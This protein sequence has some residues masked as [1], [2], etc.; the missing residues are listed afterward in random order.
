ME[1]IARCELCGGNTHRQYRNYYAQCNVCKNFLH[2]C[3]SCNTDS[4]NKT[5]IIN[6]TKQ[7]PITCCKSCERNKKIEEVLNNGRKEDIK[8]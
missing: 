6:G 8:M 2:M 3:H 4:Y 7:I 1:E 5:I